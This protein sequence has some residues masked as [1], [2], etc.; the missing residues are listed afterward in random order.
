MSLR[1]LHRSLVAAAALTVALCFTAGAF[2]QGVYY[3]EI[4]KDGRIYVFS[5]GKKAD[6]FE[7]SGEMGVAITR[8]AAGPNGETLVFENEDAINL[9]NFKHNLPGE[10]F[11][12]PPEPVK[13]ADPVSV[14]VGGTIFR[15]FTYNRRAHDH[16][17]GQEHG[18]QERV[19]GAS[20][21]PQRHGQHH[22]VHQLP[23][24]ARRR[25]AH[26]DGERHRHHDTRSTRTGS[27]RRSRS[28]RRATTTA[29]WSSV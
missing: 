15:D 27:L 18:Q 19:R 29:A 21:L 25:R 1:A 2:A 6:L 11:P 24:H 4:E 13:P 22:Q 9:Y 26:L 10:Y 17:R 12:K 20:R 23:D 3:R 5:S 14:K 16:G 8:I 28:A 7:K